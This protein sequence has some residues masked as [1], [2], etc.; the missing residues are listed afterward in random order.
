MII[1][2]SLSQGK[3]TAANG[4]YSHAEGNNVESKGKYSHAEGENTIAVGQGSHAAGFGTIAFAD[5]QTSLGQYNKDKNTEDYFVIG[6]GTYNNRKDGFGVS[7]TKTYVS[8]SLVLPNLTENSNVKVL[9]YNTETKE[10]HYGSFSELSIGKA[11][12]ATKAETAETATTSKYAQHAESSTYSD[13]AKS[14]L[15]ASYID[16]STLNI[17]YVQNA[18]TAINASSAERAVVASYVEDPNVVKTQN[19]ILKL[20]NVDKLPWSSEQGA[21]A[22]YNNKLYFCLGV[23]GWQEV[24]LGGEIISV[25]P[26]SA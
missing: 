6:T 9:T 15:T 11:E 8:N 24:M 20:K 2:S 18:S 23:Y 4:E 25:P 19:D 5:Y 13:Q 26:P 1:T 10:V 14:A 7:K 17:N 16:P 12:Q 3:N 22:L 21:L